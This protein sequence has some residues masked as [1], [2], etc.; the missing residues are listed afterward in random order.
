MSFEDIFKKYH[1]SEEFECFTEEFFKK[2]E[3]EIK[4]SLDMFIDN[5]YLRI[6]VLKDVIELKKIK[7]NILNNSND[8]SNCRVLNKVDLLI[9]N[10]LTNDDSLSK[11]K[12]FKE[13]NCRISKNENLPQVSSNDFQEKIDFL[14]EREM[15]IEKSKG[16]GKVYSLH[17]NGRL[18]EA[19]QNDSE[20]IKERNVS[21]Q[22]ILKDIGISNKISCNN[23]IDDNIV[24]TSKSIE[25][26]T[27]LLHIFYQ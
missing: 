8:N 26:N 21:S 27:V 15:I 6:C 12:L 10:C 5:P 2:T 1:L 11:T 13:L 3:D 19:N 16:K 7:E 20:M 22:S 25:E 24:E 23:Q 4:L 17:E 18:A 9:L 14:I